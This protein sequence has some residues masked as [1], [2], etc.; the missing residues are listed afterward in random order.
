MKCRSGGPEGPPFPRDQFECNYPIVID[1]V[2]IRPDGPPVGVDR[3]EI[4]SPA[5][6]DVVST[7]EHVVAAAATVHVN[8]ATATP[9]RIAVNA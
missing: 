4:V 7:S 3:R 8:P 1:Q 5:V 9:L 6:H 2:A